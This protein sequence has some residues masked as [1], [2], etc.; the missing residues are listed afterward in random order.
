MI[1]QTDFLGTL[2][3]EPSPAERLAALLN[4]LEDSRMTRARRA[5]VMISRR[6]PH[7]HGRAM[8][9]CFENGDGNTVAVTLHRIAE[10]WPDF[11]ENLLTWYGGISPDRAQLR[12]IWPDTRARLAHLHDNE[13]PAHAALL[14]EQ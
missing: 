6:S 14:T 8:D 5:F 7:W 10:L 13:L 12:D 9:N 3:V 2:A 1:A 11:A 4:L